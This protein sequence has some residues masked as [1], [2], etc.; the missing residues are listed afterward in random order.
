MSQLLSIY[1]ATYYFGSITRYKPEAFATILSSPIGRFVYEFFANQPSQFLYLMAS[2][3][4]E[5]EIA[6]AAVT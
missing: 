4:A 3:F 2:E 5:Q 1:M 6:R